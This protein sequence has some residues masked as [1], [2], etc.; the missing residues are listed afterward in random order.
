MR[1]T[2]RFTELA[3]IQK[4]LVGTMLRS[5]VRFGRRRDDVE[6]M[7]GM[8]W[9][10]GA[11]AAAWSVLVCGFA[12]SSS[13]P[14]SSIV[15]QAM[16]NA[17]RGSHARLVGHIDSWVMAQ[18]EAVREHFVRH[19]ARKTPSQLIATFERVLD[20]LLWAYKVALP[21]LALGKLGKL[22]DISGSGRHVSAVADDPAPG[23][24]RASRV[25]GERGA[26]V[27]GVDGVDGVGRVDRGKRA[28]PVKPSARPSVRHIETNLLDTTVLDAHT[29][30]LREDAPRCMIARVERQ[31]EGNTYY[32][33]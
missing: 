33:R 18:E 10:Y 27:D 15:S 31:E 3:S 1:R 7:R 25:G 19:M 28:G 6:N 26:I 16:T 17:S 20:W 14:S 9:K 30:N 12:A 4:P 11:V 8:V 32:D 29:P 5:R 23:A 2:T 13:E 22:A 21:L 24:G